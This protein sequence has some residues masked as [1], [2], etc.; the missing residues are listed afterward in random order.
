MQVIDYALLAVL[1]VSALVGVLRGLV[2]E[3]LSLAGWVAAFWCAARFGSAAS[4]LLEPFIAQPVFRLWASRLVVFVGVLFAASLLG[5]LLGYMVRNSV[6]TGT[7]RLLGMLFGVARG[8][9][10]AGLLVLA[11]ELAG[12]AAEPWW[13]QSKLIPYAAAVGQAMRDAAEK[14]FGSPDGGAPAAPGDPGTAVLGWPGQRPER[15]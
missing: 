1:L 11:L 3:A 8:V 7:D 14:R 6:I 10:I 12:F 4:G 5:W 13:R 15:S 2:R 9:L